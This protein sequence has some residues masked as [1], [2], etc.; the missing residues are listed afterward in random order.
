MSYLGFSSGKPFKNVLEVLF[1]IILSIQFA[2]EQCGFIHNDLTPWNII[3]QTLKEPIT[4][5][6]PLFSGIYKIITKHVP[7]IIDYGKSHVA[8]SPYGDFCLNELSVGNVIHYGVVNMFNMIECQDVFSIILY[9]CLDMLTVNGT[10]TEYDE[11]SIIKMLNFFSPT[12]LKTRKEALSFIYQYKKYENLIK[13]HET[14]NLEKSPIEFIKY[15]TSIFKKEKVAYGLS[16][17]DSKR[18]G[19]IMDFNNPKQIFDEAF[20]QNIQEVY[21]SFLN[22]PQ[23]LYKCTL[24]QPKTK[25]ELYM[26]AQLLIKCLKDTLRDYRIFAE[27]SSLR[28]ESF[29][30][31]ILKFENAINFITTF[32]SKEISKHGNDSWVI[33]E[34]CENNQIEISRNYFRTTSDTLNYNIKPCT[35]LTFFKKTI[36]NILNWTDDEGLFEIKAE[37]RV[38]I[39]TQ[40][41]FVLES[42][43]KDKKIS[44][45]NNT[46]IVYK[47]YCI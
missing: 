4:I 2:Q 16:R 35:D 31:D 47:K 12:E 7:V 46:Y 29:H 26:V 40:L 19:L 25:I 41:K 38:E 6:Y 17:L 24:P 34:L 33:P 30:N 32:Y 15:C 9:S 20:A 1:Q 27:K 23:N 3:I 39:S 45:N 5:Q 28:K 10:K 44:A 36:L 21:I 8:T 22:V 37:D 42:T 11:Q 13:A 14:I 43:F 18:T